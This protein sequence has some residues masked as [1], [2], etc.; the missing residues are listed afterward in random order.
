MSYIWVYESNINLN[1][2]SP[3]PQTTSNNY[4]S[5]I[6]Y[7]KNSDPNNNGYSITNYN[8]FVEVNNYLNNQINDFKNA[9]NDSSNIN[10]TSNIGNIKGK[11]MSQ[12][13]QDIY[14]MQQTLMNIMQG[15][16]TNYYNI[17]DPS[18]I[19][20]ANPSTKMS[21]DKLRNNILNYTNYNEKINNGL[22]QLNGTSNSVT[23][24][25]NILLDSTIYST[26]LWTIL[27]I[28]LLYYI[29]IGL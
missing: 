11:T 18:A 24:S 8:S 12:R 25:Q 28:C 22:D 26:V 4:I 27:A 14:S 2:L 29:F 21:Y 23:Y 15:S 16:L 3:T 17:S 6:G 7:G 5:Y 9:F 1:T 10:T 20:T 19:N 13:F